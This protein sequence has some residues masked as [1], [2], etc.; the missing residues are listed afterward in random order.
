MVCKK[1][2]LKLNEQ[3]LAVCVQHCLTMCRPEAWIQAPAQ[4]S[5]TGS[6]EQHCCRHEIVCR[7]NIQGT[8]LG[9]GQAGN[10]LC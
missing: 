6:L 4:H 8:M 2:A 3:Q 1:A 10:F 9:F 5:V 7:A